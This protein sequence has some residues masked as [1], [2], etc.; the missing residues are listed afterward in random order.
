MRFSLILATL[1]RTTELRTLLESLDRQA[2]RDFEVIV[3]DQNADNRL[4][5]IVSPF[6]NRLKMRR[7][8]AAPGLSHARNLGLQE[9]TGDVICFPDDDCWYTED[10]LARVNRLF[11]DNPS[12][13]GLIGD[14]VDAASRPTLPWCDREGKLTRPMCWRRAISYA[15]F[16]RSPVIGEIGG[17]DET[18]GLGA[19]TSWG[20]GEDNDLIL[21]TLQA[22]CHVQYHPNIRIYHPRLFP[23]F[24]ESGWSKRRSY[25]MGDGK[26]L[27]KHPMPLWW[28]LLFFSVPV[29]RAALAALRL[30]RREIYFHW[31]TLS[32]RLKGFVSAGEPNDARV[33][34]PL[35]DRAPVP[36]F[37]DATK[38]DEKAY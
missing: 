32:G 30:N 24:N 11:V 29:C 34:F 13:Q 14:S 27:R 12:W 15:L 18:L 17:F 4:L 35:K 3:V 7:L 1:G 21:R 19:G 20:S 8:V 28:K 10:V 2:H 33:A 6:E 26:L 31:I 25:A 5:P 38:G 37:A 36:E 22:G 9:I 23:V 16:L